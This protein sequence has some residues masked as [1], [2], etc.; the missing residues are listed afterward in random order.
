M[1]MKTFYANDIEGCV[2][3]YD[4]EA[5]INTDWITCGSDTVL[6]MLSHCTAETLYFKVSQEVYD[7]VLEIYNIYH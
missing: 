4:D 6:K 5:P 2:K 7:D 1:T 3:C